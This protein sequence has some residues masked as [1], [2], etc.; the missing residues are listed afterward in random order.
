MY[1]K[2]LAEMGFSNVRGYLFY[3]TNLE[4]QEVS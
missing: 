1:K 3:T 4:L 2:V